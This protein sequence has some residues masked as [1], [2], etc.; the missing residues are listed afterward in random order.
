MR[1]VNDSP[2]RLGQTHLMQITRSHTFDHPIDQCWAMFHDPASHVSKFEAMGHRDLHVLEEEV[3]DTSLRMVIERLVDVD[4]P[5]FAKR[6]IRPTNT[7]RSVDQWRDAGD[8]TYRGTFELETKGVP[9]GI[10]GSTVLSAA[11][12]ATTYDVT[13]ELKVK[14]P[15]IGG[16]IA[17]YSKGIV[18]QQMADEFRLGDEWL[19]S[20]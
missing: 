16:S 10:H 3:T 8:G 14:V 2:G 18:D 5:G 17:D 12:D 9:I 11:G 1:A 6:V 19:A 13:I 7:L 20:H 4:V 15:L